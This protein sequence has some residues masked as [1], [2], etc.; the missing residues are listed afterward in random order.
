MA[1]S[2]SRAKPRRGW[3]SS[4]FAG[5]APAAIAS[6]N[7]PTGPQ[8][9][10]GSGHGACPEPNDKRTGP[11]SR[12]DGTSDVEQ[13]TQRSA[14]IERDSVGDDAQPCDQPFLGDGLHVLAFRVAD[15]VES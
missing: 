7:A 15:F 6:S 9:G 14:S 4:A 13:E 2:G 8:D 3:L 10:L 1:E 12:Q 5:A 11:A